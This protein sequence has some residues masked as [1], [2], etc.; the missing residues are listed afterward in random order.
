MNHVFEP[1][2]RLLKEGVFDMWSNMG[3]DRKTTSVYVFL[4]TDLLIVAK[5]KKDKYHLI[6]EA[7]MTELLLV[8]GNRS[9]SSAGGANS[10]TKP[11]PIQLLH[12]GKKKLIFQ[13]AS[14]KDKDAWIKAL[15]QCHLQ[16]RTAK[17]STNASD[18]EREAQR[19]SSP[20]N[21]RGRTAGVV[22]LLRRRSSSSRRKHSQKSVSSVSTAGTSSVSDKNQTQGASVDLMLLRQN[23][24][25][26]ENR[27]PT[28]TASP[29]RSL[30]LF[31]FITTPGD[32]TTTVET[33]VDPLLLAQ[34]QRLKVVGHSLT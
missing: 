1:S 5:K 10:D 12:A 20:S 23:L 29:S 24:K 6:Q 34:R 33:K 16:S 31:S 9:A 8:G 11:T 30:S 28:N 32:P 19:L 25:K 26:V 14:D 2:R 18:R 4:F 27:K 3:P 21:N 22:Q 13:A 17:K 7:P 15:T